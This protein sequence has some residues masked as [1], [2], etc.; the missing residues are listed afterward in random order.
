MRYLLV[1]F[2]LMAPT[3]AYGQT[4]LTYEEYHKLSRE[5]QV[6][7]F[8]SLSLQNRALIARTQAT[9]WLDVNR[10]RLSESQLEAFQDVVE[11]IQPSLYDT[12]AA[13]NSLR[14]SVLESTMRLTESGLFSDLEIGMAFGAGA[15]YLP[16]KDG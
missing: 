6:E 16:E 7:T 4:T 5:Q 10:D 3:L 13:A 8:N 12:T 14:E 2:L 9:H 1:F 11:L 15:P